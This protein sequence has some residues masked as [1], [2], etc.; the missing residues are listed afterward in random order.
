ML[1]PEATPL[2]IQNIVVDA[3]N[4]GTSNETLQEATAQLQV[5]PSVTEIVGE[6][7]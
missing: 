6:M 4:S 3:S 1:K 7:I 5:V 2:K